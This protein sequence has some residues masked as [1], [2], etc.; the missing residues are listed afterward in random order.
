MCSMG[1]MGSMGRVGIICMQVPGAERSTCSSA[2]ASHVE[3]G[4]VL[5]IP[6][7]SSL[8][9]LPISSPLDIITPL[10]APIACVQ[11]ALQRRTPHTDS[12]GCTRTA[13]SGEG[14]L[15][16]TLQ[17]SPEPTQV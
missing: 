12:S 10:A 17:L 2:S 8:R 15:G 14:K 13:L 5:P 11:G 6:R 3:K 7:S 9:A 16:Q 1:S 4:R